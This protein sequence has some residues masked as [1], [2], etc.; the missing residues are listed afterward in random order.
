MTMEPSASL[1]I[2][3]L[4]LACAC[5]GSPAAKRQDEAAPVFDAFVEHRA[6][7][8]AARGASARCLDESHWQY[9]IGDRVLR[10]H[11]ELR[12]ELRALGHRFPESDDEHGFFSTVTLQMRPQADASYASVQ[13]LVQLA[14]AAGIVR[15]QVSAAADAE[16]TPR[17][18]ASGSPSPGDPELR[19]ALHWDDQ[20]R[21]TKIQIG[22]TFLQ[23]AAELRAAIAS[24]FTAAG[25]R[26]LTLVIDAASLVP[27]SEV[28]RVLGMAPGLHLEFA[29]GQR[30]Q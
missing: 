30:F 26:P 2:G 13:R 1:A 12:S 8:C 9:R 15:L 22:N 6:D 27:W 7:D 17:A 25:D 5:A 3:L 11:D 4:L 24:A 14:A 16:V 29:F 19:V 10:T 18:P 21:R 28:T 20:N 23:D